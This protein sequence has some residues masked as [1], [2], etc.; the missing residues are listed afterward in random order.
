MPANALPPVSGFTFRQKNLYR[1]RA[2]IPQRAARVRHRF[3][4]ALAQG[5]H[6][7]PVRR[8]SAGLDD[9][10]RAGGEVARFLARVAQALDREARGFKLRAGV[11]RRGEEARGGGGRPGLRVVGLAA[12]PLRDLGQ[13][14]ARRRA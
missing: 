14:T 1:H 9:G 2:A 11:L 3:P 6:D 5:Q 10:A 7:G 8:L 12:R 4:G 13:G